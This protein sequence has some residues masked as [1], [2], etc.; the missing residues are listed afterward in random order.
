MSPGQLGICQGLLDYQGLVD[1]ATVDASEIPR[2]RIP[3]MVLKPHKNMVYFP[4]QLVGRIPS[5]NSTNWRLDWKSGYFFGLN[6]FERMFRQIFQSSIVG[7]LVEPRVVSNTQMGDSPISTGA[8][9]DL[10]T[11]NSY[12]HLYQRGMEILSNK[13]Q[14]FTSSVK[15]SGWER[16]NLD[17]RTTPTQSCCIN[18]TQT[19][20]FHKHELRGMSIIHW[21]VL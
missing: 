15:C 2:P 9:V 20:H 4:Y 7:V 10:W 21:I 12:Y 6:W 8:P 3:R 17:R 18:M 19:C 16:D 11:I 13:P 14:D 1:G 5:I